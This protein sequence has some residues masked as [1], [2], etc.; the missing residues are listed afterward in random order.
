MDLVHPFTWLSPA[1]RLPVFV[2]LV[3]LTFVVLGLMASN[4]PLKKQ[5]PGK[6]GIVDFELAGTLDGAQTILD[7][8]GERGKLIA[9]LNL[10]M[11]YLYL[12]VYSSCISLGC[13]LVAQ[14]LAGRVAFL[15]PAGIV[16]AW[17]QFGA[18]LLDAVENYALIRL[19]LGPERAVWPPLARWCAIPKFVVVIAGLAFALIGGVF[20]LVWS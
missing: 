16:L 3:V 2:A 17:A 1:A 9:G 15:G 6:K 18:G 12:V 10:G 7:D 14:A 4:G 11:D 5:G 19:L 13:V 8:W 20:A